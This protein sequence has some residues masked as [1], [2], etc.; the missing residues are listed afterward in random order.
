MTI[1]DTF[2]IYRINYDFP[3]MITFSIYFDKFLEMKNFQFVL[4]F[5]DDCK[6]I[7][8]L[9]IIPSI[10]NLNNGIQYSL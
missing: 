7:V 2:I 6:I 10:E 1:L 5:F 4:V 9:I 3:Y 8:Q